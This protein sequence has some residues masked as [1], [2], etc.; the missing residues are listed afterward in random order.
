M[1]NVVYESESNVFKMCEQHELLLE[2][3][4]KVKKNNIFSAYVEAKLKKVSLV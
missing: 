4:F 1:E 3:G 2:T